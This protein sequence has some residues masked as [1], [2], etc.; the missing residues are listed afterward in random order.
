MDDEPVNGPSPSPF[1][2]ESDSGF[3]LNPFSEM[4]TLEVNV[5]AELSLNEKHEGLNNNI[6]KIIPNY[7]AVLQ[8]EPYSHARISERCFVV[9]ELDPKSGYLK[10]SWR[11]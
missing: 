2:D 11:I 10:V 1:N 6:K 9:Q 5:E 8:H 4:D 3:S 7:W